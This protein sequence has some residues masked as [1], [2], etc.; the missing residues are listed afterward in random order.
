MLA[1]LAALMLYGLIGG[2]LGPDGRARVEPAGAQ[3][4]KAQGLVGDH[5]LYATIRDRVMAGEDYYAAAAAEHR[6]NRY[7]LKPF[8]TVRLP[9]LAEI[10]AAVGWTGGRIWVAVI[11]IAA[12]LMWR[13]RLMVDPALPSY[14]RFAALLI[15]VNM[16]Q[17]LAEQWILIH[18]TVAGAL[19]ALALAVYRPEKPLAAIA[20]MAL[21]VAIRETALPVA[22]ILG[23]FALI[24]RD[25][26]AIAAWL[27]LGLAAL[28]M[29]YLHQQA[30][31][32]VVTPPDLASPGWDGQG[33][34]HAYLAFVH[35]VSGFRFLPGWMAAIIVPLALFGWSAWR[36]RLAM[37]VLAVQL[38]YTAV[39]M[40]F[41]RPNNF[42]WALLVVPTL[43]IGLIFVPAALAEL[44]RA[45]RRTNL[46]SGAEGHR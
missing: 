8:F 13:K 37:A 16:S 10:F 18:E 39:L 15:A 36:S 46:N 44:A 7:P 31:A 30:V 9:T 42:Y 6:A 19:I 23:C 20:V 24:D 1:L 25:W 3:A 14:A 34:W 21:A 29:L 33:G 45:I 40:L 11:G 26:R 35:H 41:A 32:Q 28:L 38:V 4:M 17:V 12:I 5:A 43:Y 27:G 22:I 2:A